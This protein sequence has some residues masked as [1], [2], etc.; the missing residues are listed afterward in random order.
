MTNAPAAPAS[1]LDRAPRPVRRVAIASFVGTALE[2]YDFYVFAYFAAFFVG[3]LFFE[4][5]GVFGGTL[6][7]FLSIALAFVVRPLGAIVFGHLGDRIGR[8]STLIVTITLMGV[9][10]GLIGVLPDYAT[11]GWLGAIGLVVLRILQG[12]SLGGEWGGAVL[13]ATEHAD[14]RRRPFFAAIPQ[15]GS[16]VGSIL[17]ATVFLV[18]TTLLTTEDMVAWGWRIPFL[19]AIP[20][21]LVSLYL[22]W[23]IDETPVFR[24][25]VAERRRDRVPFL[26]MFARQPVAILV[27]VGAALL[28]IGSY[29][30]MNTY[31]VN[32]GVTELGFSFQDLLVATTI[33][34]LLQLV[35]IPTFGWLATRVGSAR[36]VAWGALGTLLITFPMY[37]LLQFATFPILVGTMIIGGILPTMAWASLGGLMGDLFDDHYRYSALSFAYS[38]AA[39]ISGFVPALTL[40]LGEATA[41]EWWHPGVVLAVMSAITLGS[42]LAAGAIARSRAAA[43]AAD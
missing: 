13:L 18:M 19:T 4:P 31:T 6:S 35:T 20:L 5:L 22:R 30:L 39:V 27:A 32:Y 33:G 9:A 34:G 40:A 28:G 14:P 15:L 42:A 11:A 37:W 3:P 12:L 7:A 8:R 2:S 29:S 43:P 26:A 38:I 23:S 17:S 16:P 24:E 41:F 25:L 1:D 36:V 10:T 21:L